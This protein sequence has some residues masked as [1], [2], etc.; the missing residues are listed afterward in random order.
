MQYDMKKIGAG[1]LLKIKWHGAPTRVL[2]NGE[3]VKRDVATGDVLEVTVEQARQLLSMYRLFTLEGDEPMAQA[4][5][6][7]AL[8]NEEKKAKAESGEITVE[9]AEKLE[10]KKDVID[11]LKKLDVSF[12]DQANKN[13]LKS[14][15]VETLKEREAAKAAAA[16]T[17]PEANTGD[18]ANAAGND[19]SNQS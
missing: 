7:Y 4:A 19:A 2:V 15:L 13:E 17:A 9:D 14:L 1:T 12:N 6:V 11:A 3:L 5:P 18:D 16:N 8:T 10:K